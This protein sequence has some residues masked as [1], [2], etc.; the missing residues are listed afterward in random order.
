VTPQRVFLLF[1]G[2]GLA[3][4]LVWAFVVL[5]PRPPIDQQ[6]VAATAARLR[7]RLFYVFGVALLVVFVWSLRWLPYHSTRTSRL[8]PP[9]VTVEVA[10][11]QWAWQLAPA[12]VPTGVPVEF[13]VTARDVNHGLGVYD[14]AGRLLT[15]VQAM[16]GY[17]NR[18]VWRFDHP[19]TYTL[20]C[21]EYCGLAHHAMLA[22]LTV[23]GEREAR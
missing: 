1:L 17:T 2:L 20:R 9:A 16:P 14:P 13:A 8:G 4:T 23:T 18:L 10:G 11:L 19:G 22:T 15:Q 6:Q 7:R 21:L 5:R 12:E 3:W